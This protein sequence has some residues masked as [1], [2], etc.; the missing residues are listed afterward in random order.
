MKTSPNY[1]D[2]SVDEVSQLFQN[3]AFWNRA[4]YELHEAKKNEAYSIENHAQ[5]HVKNDN[6][7]DNKDDNKSDV[8][9]KIKM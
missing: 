7:N 8:K 1:K 6:K 5:N 2:L 9:S 3:E 4:M